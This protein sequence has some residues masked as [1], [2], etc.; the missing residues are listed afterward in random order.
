ME[1]EDTMDFELSE[2]MRMLADMAYKFAVKEIE[3][4]AAEADEQEHYTPEVRKKAGANGLIGS[5]IPEA[6]GGAGVG[7]LGNTIITEQL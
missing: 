2:E 3:P 7:F 5:W 1:K 4:I 6:Y